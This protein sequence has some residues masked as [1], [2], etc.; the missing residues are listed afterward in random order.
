MGCWGKTDSSD[1]LFLS[2]SLSLADLTLEKHK[3]TE[4]IK[5]QEIG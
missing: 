4:L 5:V 3:F 2:L 1:V